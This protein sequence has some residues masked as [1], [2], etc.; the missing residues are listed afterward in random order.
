MRLLFSLLIAVGDVKSSTMLLSLHV[1]YQSVVTLVCSP[2]LSAL[3]DF[4]V[5][6][7]ARP[8]AF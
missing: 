5:F 7:G 1:D 3:D 2:H 4:V 6:V 8:L